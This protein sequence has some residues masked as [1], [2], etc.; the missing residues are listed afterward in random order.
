MTQ[1]YFLML[2]EHDVGFLFYHSAWSYMVNKKETSPLPWPARVPLQAGHY[3]VAEVSFPAG[4]KAQ[5]I[6]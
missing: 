1:R 4:V 5:S 2:P 3:L 6:H